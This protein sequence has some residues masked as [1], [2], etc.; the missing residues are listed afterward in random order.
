MRMNLES[1]QK[2]QFLKRHQTKERRQKTHPE[3]LQIMSHKI[4]IV[5]KKKEKHLRKTTI[6]Q[7]SQWAQAML[8]IYERHIVEID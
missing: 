5:E 7:R 8:N 1:I 3:Q 4:L 6:S 2:Y